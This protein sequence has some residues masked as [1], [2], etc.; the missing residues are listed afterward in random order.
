MK[1]I[2]GLLSIFFLII[3]AGSFTYLI[4]A[5]EIKNIGKPINTIGVDFSPSLTSDGKI[6]VFDSKLPKEKSHNIF[7]SYKKNGKWSKPIY[8]KE[9]NSDGNDETPYITHDGS[10]IIFASD[11]AGSKYPP[12]TS[13]GKIRVTYDIYVT[14]RLRNRWS[15]PIPIKGLVN[16]YN[17]ERSPRLSSDKRHIF[18]TRYRFNKFRKSVLMMATLKDGVYGDVKELPD[19]IN[20]KNFEL[21][22]TEAYYRNGYYFSS[23]R[24]G[25]YGGWDLYFIPYENNKFGK[26]INLGPT[27][28]SGDNE[29]FVCQIKGELYFSSNKWDSLGKYDIYKAPVPK[30]LYKKIDDQKD[31]YA[32]YKKDRTQTNNRTKT[33]DKSLIKKDDVKKDDIIIKKDVIKKNDTVVKKDDVKKNDTVVKKDDVKKNDTVVKKDDTKKN[34]TVIKK[35]DIKKDDTVI[36]KDDIKKD[37]SVVKKDDIIRKDTT[38]TSET[39]AIVL[40]VINKKNNKPVRTRISIYLKDDENSKKP[41]I[42]ST[43]RYTNYEGILKIKPKKDIRW[44]VFKIWRKGFQPIRHSVKVEPG[45]KILTSIKLIPQNDI[46][47]SKDSQVAFRN[48]YFKKGSQSIGFEYIEYLQGIANYLRNNPEIKIQLIGHSDFSGSPY[49]RYSM[50]LKRAQSIK[51]YLVKSGISQGRIHVTSLADRDPTSLRRGR[52]HSLMNRRVEFIVIKK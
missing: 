28:N 5:S 50:A 42:R 48:I 45:Y 22:F 41:E 27:I 19:S 26:V 38:V 1:S 15:T 25:G 31:P 3:L 23:R 29:L 20:T 52:Y 11:R 39:T 51:N 7:I 30:S 35:D 49:K 47:T 14:R 40:K 24:P 37:D 6:M 13:D 44:V 36:K 12:V 34:D 43:Y 21:G 10:A 9:I 17:N 16:T 32:D 4:S 8:I 46:M 2:K 18:F 33:D